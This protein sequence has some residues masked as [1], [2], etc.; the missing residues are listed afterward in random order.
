[1]IEMA[2]RVQKYAPE[3]LPKIESGD[4]TLSTACEQLSATSAT[5]S[6]RAAQRNGKNSLRIAAVPNGFQQQVTLYHGDAI[7]QM[8][9]LPSNSVDAC[10]TSVPYYLLK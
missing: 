7:E 8:R 10:V 6:K 4:L 2:K 5:S 3:L 9:K 1:M